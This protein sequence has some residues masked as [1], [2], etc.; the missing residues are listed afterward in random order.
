MKEREPTKNERGEATFFLPT[1]E[2]PQPLPQLADG[3]GLK[4]LVDLE[5]A[6]CLCTALKANVLGIKLNVPVSLSL[7]LNACGR[8]TSHGFICA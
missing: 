1:T 8:K 2:P 6:A 3:D 4:G 7:L 5:A